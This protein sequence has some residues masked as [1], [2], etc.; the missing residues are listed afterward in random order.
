MRRS[1]TTALTFGLTL[2]LMS[3][4]Q[5]FAQD[6]KKESTKPTTPAPAD[7]KPTTPVPDTKTAPAATPK[8]EVEAPLPT[9][10]PEVEAK[11]E[12]ARKAV[13]EAIVAVQDAGLVETSIDPPPVLDILITGR[14]L[15]A[16]DLKSRRGVSPE[17]FA[18][19]FTGYGKPMEGITPQENV[20]IV[21]PSA[22]LKTMYDQRAS[23][24]TRHIEAVRKAKLAAAAAATPKAVTPTPVVVPTTPTPAT[25]KIE[26]K[27]EEAKKAETKKAE[28]KKEDAK[29]AETK[30]DTS[31]DEVKKDAPK[32][33]DAKP[34]DAKKDEVKKDAPKTD[35]KAADP[36]KD[37]TKKN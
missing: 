10:P 19:W 17:V 13:A 6:T 18:A 30:K 12:A 14:A 22:G 26:M 21:E 5:L 31:K 29:P 25:P 1:V 27:K 33:D 32:T 4:G 2:G 7:T 28:T 24:F 35:A 15:D 8:K 3:I 11:L 16:R 20:R 37:E 34:A 23:V 9:I 36:K